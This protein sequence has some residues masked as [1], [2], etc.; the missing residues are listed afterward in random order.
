MID[1]E[2]LI[3]LINGEMWDDYS[4]YRGLGCI[5]EYREY[6]IARKGVWKRVLQLIEEVSQ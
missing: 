2:K 6:F 1:E 4:A 3:E 5:P